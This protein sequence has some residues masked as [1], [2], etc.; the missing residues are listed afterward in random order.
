[1]RFAACA[2]GLHTRRASKTVNRLSRPKPVR[3]RRAG[4]I[5][6]HRQIHATAPIASG[7]PAGP[8]LRAEPTEADSECR[9][10][11]AACGSQSPPPP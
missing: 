7:A 1:M 10:A 8:S 11:G 2:T 3:H 5:A 9:S 4:P 6:V